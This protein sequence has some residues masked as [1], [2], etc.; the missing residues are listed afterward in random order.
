MFCAIDLVSN[1]YAVTKYR[2]QWHTFNVGFEVFKMRT[3]HCIKVV[4][5]FV[6]GTTGSSTG[7]EGSESRGTDE[8]TGGGGGSANAALSLSRYMLYPRPIIRTGL[9]FGHRL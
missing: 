5:G 1:E 6:M 2:A 9:T 4:G 7:D 8:M 3:A